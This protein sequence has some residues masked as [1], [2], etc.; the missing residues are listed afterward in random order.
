M[1]DKYNTLREMAFITFLD[2]NIHSITYFP[3]SSGQKEADK[4]TNK[5]P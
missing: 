5:P 4:Q 2:K 1:T 3:F